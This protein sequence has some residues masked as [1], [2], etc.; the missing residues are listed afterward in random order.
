MKILDK[1]HKNC[2]TIRELAIWIDWTTRW[3]SL[4]KK[5]PNI[6]SK[7]RYSDGKFSTPD[8]S[9]YDYDDNK[10][11]YMQSIKCIGS[12]IYWINYLNRVNERLLNFERN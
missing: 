5:V 1:I 12:C 3:Y 6:S 2:D 8:I 4:Q 10:L 11:H 9:Y 7:I